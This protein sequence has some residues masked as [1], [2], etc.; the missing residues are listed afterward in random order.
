M[1]YSGQPMIS[2]QNNKN[3]ISKRI[4]LFEFPTEI[5]TNNK[6]FV[7]DEVSL[8]EK[9]QIIK[10][11]E[12]QLDKIKKVNLQKNLVCISLLILLL[13]IFILLT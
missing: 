7:E 9:E 1:G 10:R 12:K 3:L 2:V 11:R 13:T 5:L 6:K 4:K 8:Y